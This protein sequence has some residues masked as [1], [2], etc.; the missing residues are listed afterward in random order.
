MDAERLYE[1]ISKDEVEM[2]IESHIDKFIDWQ[3]KIDTVLE[4]GK[5]P[6]PEAYMA[7]GQMASVRDYCGQRARWLAEVIGVDA[8]AIFDKKLEA[9]TC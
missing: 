7:I 1:V 8:D 9:A 5:P 2:L 3:I 6:T 4:A